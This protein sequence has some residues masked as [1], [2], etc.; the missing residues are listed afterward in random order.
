MCE[1]AILPRENF[2]VASFRRDV[3]HVSVHSCKPLEVVNL[4][5]SF[6]P[7][8]AFRHSLSVTH[9]W[10]ELVFFMGDNIVPDTV[11]IVCRRERR[12]LG[13]PRIRRRR[14]LL[15]LRLLDHAVEQ[16]LEGALLCRWLRANVVRRAPRER[17]RLVAKALPVEPSISCQAE[18]EG[19]FGRTV[20]H[21]PTRDL[22]EVFL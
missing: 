1:D 15:V 2:L 4:R 12:C 5:N 21:F 20:G 6:R 19:A 22:R 13:R 16:V 18:I 14:V 8:E 17:L 9:R 11:Q 7:L 10:S 3:I